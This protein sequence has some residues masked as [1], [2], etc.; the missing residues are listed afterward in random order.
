MESYFHDGVNLTGTLRIRGSM[1][2]E[3]DFQGEIYSDDHFIVGKRGTI[4]G[5]VNVHD[6]TNLGKVKGNVRAEGK[7]CL[8][9]GSDLIGDIITNQLVVEN[10]VNFEG[11]C[12]MTNRKGPSKMRKRKRETPSGNIYPVSII[13]LA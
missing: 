5:K 4:R 6:F 2:F 11:H 13:S 3:G 9:A 7:V 12:K 8:I 1:H 10:D